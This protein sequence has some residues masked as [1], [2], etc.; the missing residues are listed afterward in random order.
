VGQAFGIERNVASVGAGDGQIE[1][2]VFRDVPEVGELTEPQAGAE[3]NLLV[4]S[5]LVTIIRMLFL[6]AMMGSYLRV[7]Q[8]I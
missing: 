4:L 7:L 3:T 5:A 1:S 2:G 8:G 6:S